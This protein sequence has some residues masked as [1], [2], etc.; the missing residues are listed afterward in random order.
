MLDLLQNQ[1]V[2]EVM[3]KNELLK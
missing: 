2:L 1:T 3:D